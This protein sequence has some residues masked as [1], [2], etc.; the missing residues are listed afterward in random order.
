[1]CPKVKLVDQSRVASMRRVPLHP[2][3]SNTLS[4]DCLQTEIKK[5]AYS[6]TLTNKLRIFSQAFLKL[7]PHSL[8]PLLNYLR[9]VIRQG[10]MVLAFNPRT[11]K[12]EAGRSP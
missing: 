11:P 2:K 1:M 3:S 9:K 10:M 8:P 4:T 5:W 7:S 12:T 6:T